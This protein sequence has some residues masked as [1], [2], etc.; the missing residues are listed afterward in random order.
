MEKS[1]HFQNAQLRNI[2]KRYSIRIKCRHLRERP[3]CG[4]D[5][6]I[7][8]NIV[9]HVCGGDLQRDLGIVEPPV[10]SSSLGNSNQ[11]S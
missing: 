10:S 2:G 7:L 11:Q 3:E 8:V 1:V 6:I 4:F 9:H 5:V